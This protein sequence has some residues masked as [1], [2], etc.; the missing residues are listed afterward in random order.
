MAIF[1]SSFLIVCLA[2]LG[3]AVGALAGRRPIAGGCGAA[4][5]ADEAGIGC[6]ACGAGDCDSGDRRETS[7]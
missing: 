4:D 7:R 2:V 1:L 6:G 3:M 5:R